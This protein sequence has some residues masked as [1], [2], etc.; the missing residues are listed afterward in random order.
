MLEVD[1]CVI[2]R[3]VLPT[4]KQNNKIIAE[5]I[6]ENNKDL[7]RL[8]IGELS[9]RIGVSEAAIIRFCKA[10]GMQGYQELKINT[11]QSQA[12]STTE[13]EDMSIDINEKDPY[14]IATKIFDNA[15]SNLIISK[16]LINGSEFTS[17]IERLKNCDKAIFL[18]VGTSAFIAEDASYRFMRVGFQTSSAVDP[19]IMLFSANNLTE[20][21]VAI[22]ISHTG[23]S[24][25]TIEAL[26]M[27]K[28]KNAFTVVITSSRNSPITKHC[29][30]AL[31]TTESKENILKEAMASRLSHVALLDSIFTTLMLCSDID[32]NNKI[33]SIHEILK[34]ARV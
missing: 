15:I 22:A 9:K 2:I 27:A 8:S 31:V 34:N 21:S 32:Y 30:V 5:Y 23:K 3:N 13:F 29:D 1:A 26:K 6:L 7:A 11:L 19:H 28:S 33:N 14:A 24:K 10:I 18:A 16:K 12:A 4:L 17:V 20:N 25:E